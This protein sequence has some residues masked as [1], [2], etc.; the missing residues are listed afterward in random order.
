LALGGILWLGALVAAVSWS[1]VAALR[2][3]AGTPVALALAAFI[4]FT[5]NAMADPMLPVI[6]GATAAFFA[7]RVRQ[8]SHSWPSHRRTLTLDERR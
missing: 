4:G 1:A 7:E 2:R 8:D 6:V 5:H 3:H